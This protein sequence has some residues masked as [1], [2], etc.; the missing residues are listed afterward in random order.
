MTNLARAESKLTEVVGR[1]EEE[2]RKKRKGTEML[3]RE[4]AE[5]VGAVEVANQQ[6]INTYNE[7]EVVKRQNMVRVE[8]LTKELNLTKRKLDNLEK[9]EKPRSCSVLVVDAVAATAC[10]RR[11]RGRRRHSPSSLGCR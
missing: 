9:R 4:L 7:L 2:N 5:R 8:E 1:L 6:V 10:T 3:A 11:W